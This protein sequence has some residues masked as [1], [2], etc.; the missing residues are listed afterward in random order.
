[1]T[2]PNDIQDTIFTR[3]FAELAEKFNALEEAAE[4]ISTDEARRMRN[5]M[6]YALCRY[7]LED[8]PGFVEWLLNLPEPP[9]EEQQNV[10]HAFQTISA[11]K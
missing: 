9:F 7:V 11:E 1:M 6:A 8:N 10:W 2:A 3:L 4:L 5:Q